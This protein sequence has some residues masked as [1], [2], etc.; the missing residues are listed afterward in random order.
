MN[1]CILSLLCCYFKLENEHV[2]KANMSKHKVEA[3][4]KHDIQCAII[5]VKKANKNSEMISTKIKEGKS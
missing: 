1:R 4:N 2:Q 5:N 3:S